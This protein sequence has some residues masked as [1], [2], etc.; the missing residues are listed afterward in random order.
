MSEPATLALIA[1]VFLVA[2]AVKGTVGLGLPTV[3]LAL[4]AALL[5]L[6]PAMALILAPALASNVWQALAGS[7]GRALFARIWP[8]LLTTAVT[9]W[10]GV[11]VLASVREELPRALLGLVLIGY[12]GLGLFQVRVYL[13]QRW[14]RWAAPCAGAVNGVLTGITGTFV[15][16]SVLYLQAIGLSRDRLVQAMGMQ[17]LVCTLALAAALGDRQLI[18]GELA[19]LSLLAVVPALA[20]LWAGR[21]LRALC[22]EAQFR[23]LLFAALGLLGLYIFTGAAL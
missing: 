3:A 7:N 14:E 12:A 17:F 13:P 5:G 21:R 23:R 2:G 10:L 9:I 8:L 22:D 11:Q 18:D 6:Q 15:V 19:G 1:L 20:G 4:L 16:P